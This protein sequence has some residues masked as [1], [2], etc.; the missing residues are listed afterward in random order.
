MKFGKLQDISQVDFSLAAPD[1]RSREV[2]QSSAGEAFRAYVG[3]P[4]WGNK[5]WIGK[6]YPTG[7]KPADFL[8]YYAHSF[9]TIELNSTHYGM[10]KAETLL[11]W[12]EQVTPGFEFCPK[13][14]QEI[15]H[16]QKLTGRPE[17]TLLFCERI[18]LLEEKLG[19]AFL[20]LPPTFGPEQFQRLQ[21]FVMDFPP[22]IPLA[23]EFRH[24][25]WFENRHLIPQAFSLLSAHGVGTVIS[26]VSGRRD[27]SHASLTNA[28][29]MIRFV[30]N[31]LHPTDF[32]RMDAWM[33]RLQHWVE[34]GLQKL[35]LFVHEPDDLYAP[36]IGKYAIEQ[37]NQRFGLDLP[38]PAIP[39]QSGGQM[40]LF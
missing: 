26:D 29:A 16:Y 10:P 5:D 20:Q 9:N 36:D 35:Y 27:V 6:I 32:S 12:K 13:F 24:P 3:C 8:S 39:H 11:K 21:R 17:R 19:C 23:V 28:T 4:V 25:A 38:L 18:G 31:Q 14:P 1:P 40:T 22:H 2:L 7:A 33:D 34:Q 15:S 37:L 30:G